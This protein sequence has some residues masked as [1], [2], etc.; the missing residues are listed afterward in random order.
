MEAASARLIWFHAGP[1]YW[2]NWNLEML[3]VVF[4]EG[5][6]L[7]YPEK[8]TRSKT[9]TNNKLNP[10]MA[11]GQ[12]RTWATLVGGKRSH[13]SIIPAPQKFSFQSK[14]Y[15]R[16][17]FR[18]YHLEQGPHT[19]KK[20]FIFSGMWLRST[21]RERVYCQLDFGQSPG[22]GQLMVFRLHTYNHLTEPYQT[23]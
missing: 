1:Q 17:I 11:L 10:H 9:R 13:N 22:K 4:V 8:N 20:W 6:K 12:N 19:H 21:S 2:L 5:G 15:R 14:E 3:P 7:E 23:I 18:S 16:K